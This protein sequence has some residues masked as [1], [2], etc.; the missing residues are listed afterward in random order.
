M[1]DAHRIIVTA[2]RQIDARAKAQELAERNLDAARKKYDNGM[3]TSFEVSQI[4]N[5]LSDA[6]SQYLLSLAAYHKAVSAYH[7]AIADILEW[8]NV[9]VEGIPT[10]SEPPAE[11][12]DRAAYAERVLLR[13]APTGAP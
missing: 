2:S 4:Q 8:K 13:T 11:I 6:Q 5:Q 10:D 12:E 1:R 3:T 9:R 7:T